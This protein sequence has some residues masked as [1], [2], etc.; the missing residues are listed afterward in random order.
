MDDDLL[1]DYR[2]HV[3]QIA[4][5]RIPARSGGRRYAP[6]SPRGLPLSTMA[7][8]R[9]RTSMSFDRDVATAPSAST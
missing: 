7:T 9:S 1:E 6:N 4:R 8:A 2:R 5:E 3:R